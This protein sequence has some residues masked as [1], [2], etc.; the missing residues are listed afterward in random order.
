MKYCADCGKEQENAARFCPDCGAVMPENTTDTTETET[1]A[2]AAPVGSGP[3]T[4]DA[5]ATP[6]YIPIKIEN[7]LIKAIIATVCCCL[8]F[9]IVAIVYA[10]KVDSFLKSNDHAA[11]VE[12]SKKASM[13][14]NLAIGLGILQTVL[15]SL[16]YMAILSGA[17][18]EAFTEALQQ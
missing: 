5:T 9:G 1:T 15:I 14:G 17:F 8:P 10:A 2:N 16:F 4:A 18:M 6:P 12:A 7:N 11:A 3:A 13:W